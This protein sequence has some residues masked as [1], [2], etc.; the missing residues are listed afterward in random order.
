L[1]A[2]TSGAAQSAP[3]GEHA[4]CPQGRITTVFVD[5]HPIFDTS[6]MEEGTPFLWAYRLA[7]SLHF[8]TKASFIESELLLRPGDC[9]DPLLVDESERLLRQYEFLARVDVF[10]V[11]QPDG[12]QHLV[13]DTQDE[14]TTEFNVRTR[15]DPGFELAGIDLTEENLLGRGILVGGFF[16]QKREQREV[17]VRAASPRLFGTR[18]DGHIRLGKTRTGSVVEQGFFYPFVGE[19]GRLAARQEYFRRDALFSYSVEDRRPL[20]NITV[21]LLEERAEFTVAARFGD[22]GNLTFVGVG[23]S[24][25]VLEFPDFE[26]GVETVRDR[27]FGNREP[28]DP[29]FV[30]A[31][32]PQAIENSDTRINVI[33]GQRNLRFVRRRG[34]DALRGVQDIAVGTEVDLTLGRTIDFLDSDRT[35]TSDLFARTTAFWG[36]APG[37]WVTAASASLEGRQVFSDRTSAQRSGWR[38]V[39]GEFDLFGYYHPEGRHTTVARLAGAAGWRMDVPFQLTL[40]G[41]YGVRGLSSIAYPGGRRLLATAEHRVT[42]DWTPGELLDLGFT[43]FGDLG[44][45]WPGGVPFGVDS[46]WKGTLGAGLRLGFPRGT[47]GVFRIDLAFPVGDEGKHTPILRL[48]ALEIVGLVGG[49]SDGQ[50]DRSRRAGV[51]TQLIPAA[52]PGG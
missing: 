37:P 2:P 15:F 42:L 32:R 5:N 21:P 35:G 31:V 11:P 9:L 46:G 45:V 4:A 28:A 12:T 38:D 29:E 36:T 1:L 27:D 51:G 18:L 30:E 19:I 49:F 34:L 23:L 52:R 3:D 7:N 8:T 14:W 47:R 43:V 24:R 26:T 50:L 10:A 17:G 33:L 39:I 44:R 48:S 22:V 6:K 25:E 13:V 16:V 41:L 40:G 20:T